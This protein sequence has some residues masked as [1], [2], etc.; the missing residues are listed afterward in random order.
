[1]RQNGSDA[2]AHVV[3]LGDGRVPDFDSV[4]IGD[5]IQSARGQDANPQAQI[6][7]T[8]PGV[9]SGVLRDGADHQ[10]NSQ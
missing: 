1:M 5:G 9:G 2:G 6:R 7:G 3:A 10:Q 4:Y 8:W